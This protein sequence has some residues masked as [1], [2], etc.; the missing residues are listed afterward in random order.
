MF[1]LKVGQRGSEQNALTKE[2]NSRSMK[3]EWGVVGTERGERERGS[4]LIVFIVWV[5][6]LWNER[7][8]EGNRESGGREGVGVGRR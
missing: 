6:G 7:E 4:P 5:Q 1:L 8:R 2:H 3:S